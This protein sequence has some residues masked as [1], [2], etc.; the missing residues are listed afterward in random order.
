MT[1]VHVIPFLWSGAGRVVTRLC[2]EQARRHEVHLVTTGTGHGTRDWPAYVRA[3]QAA[4]VRMHAID[5]YARDAASFW[6]A[7]RDIGDLLDLVRADLV[8]THAGTPTAATV[9]ARSRVAGRRV[10]LVSH[11]YSWGPHRPAWM[12]EMDLWGFSQAD[13][14]I[15]S[16]HAYARRLRDGGVSPRRL[17]YVPWGIDPPG[18]R[19]E[20]A[21]TRQS[22]IARLGFVGRIEPRKGQLLL[23]DAVRHL[24]R[25]R[26]VRLELVG[27]V[28]DAAYGRRL[29]ESL[30]ARSGVVRLRG[31][32]RD[33]WP[34]L[35]GWDLFVSLSG[36][37]GQGLA[38]LEAMAAGVPVAA[39]GVSGV[40]DYLTDGDTG[41]VLTPG[42]ATT[43][44]RQ[45]GRVLDRPDVLARMARRARALVHRRYTWAATLS[46]IDRVYARA[47]G[48]ATAAPAP[49]G[50]PTSAPISRTNRSHVKKAR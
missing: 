35:A 5:T 6:Q 23:A 36:D 48:S 14:V 27:P 46:A 8:H 17:A 24:A 18:R 4:G 19:E 37:E 30:A 33:V 9:I 41:A 49:I 12:D 2:V 10:P 31:K 38:V 16:A 25:T 50:S 7:V 39:L 42:S 13:R 47:I 44:A 32:V 20:S 43:I 34:V 1:I 15:C 26:P 11:M 28:A 3:A 29:A 22:P 21:A 40:E 45:L